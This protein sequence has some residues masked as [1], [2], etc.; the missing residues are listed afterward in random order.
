VEVDVVSL[1]NDKCRA[2]VTNLGARLVELHVPDRDGCFG[3]VV[4][5]CP[6]FEAMA[7]DDHYMGA[8]VGRYANRIRRGQLLIDD[9]PVQLPIN[10]G[11]NHLHGGLLG[12]DRRLWSTAVS[13]SDAVTFWR[14]SPHR[15]EGYPGKLTC[16]VTYRLDGSVLSIDM[17]ATTDAATIVNIAHHSYFNLGG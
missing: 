7:A 3:D 8:T 17:Q 10:E 14:I 6:S 15:E 11:S 16:A 2:V 4:L 13:D 5:Q 12:F 1:S 9:V